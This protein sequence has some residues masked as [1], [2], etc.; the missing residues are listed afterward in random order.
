MFAMFVGV[1]AIVGDIFSSYFVHHTSPFCTVA[2]SHMINTA[3]KRSK[4]PPTSGSAV[5][6]LVRRNLVRSYVRTV[7]NPK[8]PMG[9]YEC[10]SGVAVC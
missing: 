10:I 8:G 9:I 4:N 6:V 7:I 2:N 5:Q 3:T 1:G